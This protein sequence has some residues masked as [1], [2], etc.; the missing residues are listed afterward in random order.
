MIQTAHTFLEDG[1]KR[2]NWIPA[3]AGMTGSF[4]FAPARRSYRCFSWFLN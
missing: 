3:F 4:L 1:G 2:M